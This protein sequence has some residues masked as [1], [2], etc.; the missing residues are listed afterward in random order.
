MPKLREVIGETRTKIY[1]HAT[2]GQTCAL[3]V[4][5]TIKLGLT[6]VGNRAKSLKRSE[7]KKSCIS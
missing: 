3:A 1:C 2:V 5:P 6:K 7:K 4:P